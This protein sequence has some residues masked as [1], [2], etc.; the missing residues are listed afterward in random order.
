MYDTA[1][2]KALCF[3]LREP[4]VIFPNLRKMSNQG[5]TTEQEGED[6]GRQLG[7]LTSEEMR[8]WVIS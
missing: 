4:Y 8:A 3:C 7:F 5:N 2:F 6:L 1:R